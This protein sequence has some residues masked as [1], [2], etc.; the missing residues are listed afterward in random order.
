MN[1]RYSIDSPVR[2]QTEKRELKMKK[3]GQV[4]SDNNDIDVYQPNVSID[5]DYLTASIPPED[6][7]E[8]SEQDKDEKK[9]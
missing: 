8:S 6:Q 3:E 5:M 9:P 7:D 2:N 1:C 4:L